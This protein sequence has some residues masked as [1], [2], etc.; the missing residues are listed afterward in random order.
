MAISYRPIFALIF[1]L[2]VLFSKASPLDPNA[3]ED[4]ECPADSST[5][6][7]PASNRTPPVA[8]SSSA[9]S[10]PTSLAS[11]HSN[12]HPPEAVAR[13]LIE[14]VHQDQ[15]HQLDKA[16]SDTLTALLFRAPS[17]NRP[18]TMTVTT[19]MCNE[20]LEHHQPLVSRH[21]TWTE[22]AN[23]GLRAL[24]NDALGQAPLPAPPS[25][26]RVRQS[27][28]AP[29]N[30]FSSRHRG[31]PLD[32][33]LD[34]YASQRQLSSTHR[35]HD[36]RD[37]RS[38]RHGPAAPQRNDVYPSRPR[39]P[40]EPALDYY[41]PRQFP[42]GQ[43][44]LGF[45][46][47]NPGS[48]LWTPTTLRYPGPPMTTNHLDDTEPRRASRDGRTN[49]ITWPYQHMAPFMFAGA[50]I[51]RLPERTY[52]DTEPPAP[53]VYLDT[54]E[55]NP[56][57]R[58]PLN[59]E[60]MEEEQATKE[61]RLAA[62]RVL[63]NTYH[64]SA[65]LVAGPEAFLSRMGAPTIWKRQARCH[66]IA[67]IALETALSWQGFAL[68]VNESL[69]TPELATRTWIDMGR[70]SE[71]YMHF[72]FAYAVDL[73]TDFLHD[74]RRLFHDTGMYDYVAGHRSL[75]YLVTNS[76][77]DV[78]NAVDARPWNLRIFNHHYRTYHEQHGRYP[79]I[80]FR[81]VRTGI[82]ALSPEDISFLHNR[83]LRLNYEANANRQYQPP[84]GILLDSQAP[85]QHDLSIPDRP[86]PMAARTFMG[87]PP[88]AERLQ[89]LWSAAGWRPA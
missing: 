57:S 74:L 48:A 50:L 40:G 67:L 53:P 82:G 13:G 3:P 38:S 51:P 44:P 73:V 71:A 35:P 45:F 70:P 75:E 76:L 21:L 4:G 36:R 63:W 62:Q 29:S 19:W 1:V 84:P 23:V 80:N 69:I 2:L 26:L 85:P 25:S 33:A 10:R 66:V 27:S 72:D 64:C 47:D 77:Q 68:T 18:P 42:R 31:P 81:T 88:N 87:A 39:L 49:G 37:S 14:L 24:R 83:L 34:D 30:V 56:W 20:L 9:N 32:L 86:L 46:T 58:A 79:L 54:L 61:H 5:D 41:F 6:H 17:A 59:Y 15:L 7:S 12:E 16:A 89:A 60:Q 78:V 22:V 52:I 11:P 43:R 65:T 28:S 8:S 55:A